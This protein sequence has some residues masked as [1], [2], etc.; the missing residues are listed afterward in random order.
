MGAVLR[1]GEG[2]RGGFFEAI[3]NSEFFIGR[4]FWQDIKN[5]C[6]GYAEERA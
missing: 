3:Y 6:A 4:F 1:N 2:Y 5:P